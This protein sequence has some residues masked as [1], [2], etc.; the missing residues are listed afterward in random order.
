MHC[1]IITLCCVTRQQQT[2]KMWI[3]VNVGEKSA[4]VLKFACFL[5][6]IATV[7]TVIVSL[8]FCEY[9]NMKLTYI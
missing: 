1:Y 9:I 7:Y 2:S 5:H 3:K 4:P 6:F 8:S